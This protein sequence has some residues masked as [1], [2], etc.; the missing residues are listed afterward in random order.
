L[1]TPRRQAGKSSVIQL[2]PVLPG[3][4]IIGIAFLNRGNQTYLCARILRVKFR[5]SP[6]AAYQLDHRYGLTVKPV[7]L[8]RGPV[9]AKVKVRRCNFRSMDGSG[10]TMKL[11]LR[12]GE[13]VSESQL[14]LALSVAA[15]VM[16][17]MLCAIMWQ[18][19]IIGSQR[20]VIRS[21]W[22]AKFG[23]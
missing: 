7:F 4:E 20:D 5:T 10:E 8:S 2:V 22:S 15:V 1:P 21:L 11:I 14:G 9:F 16:G 6:H 18:S 3:L 17:L 19:T 13:P 12:L 23:G